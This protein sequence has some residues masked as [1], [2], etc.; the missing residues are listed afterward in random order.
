MPKR[1]HSF[2]DCSKPVCGVITIIRGI[3]FAQN[4][5]KLDYWST[6]KIPVINFIFAFLFISGLYFH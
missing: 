2:R 4:P 3:F 5:I 6:Q 1:E